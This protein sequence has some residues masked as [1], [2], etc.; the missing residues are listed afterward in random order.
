MN[1]G[2]ISVPRPA[3]L[4]D[5]EKERIWHP[6]GLQNRSQLVDKGLTDPAEMICRQFVVLWDMV[7]SVGHILY[8]WLTVCNRLKNASHTHRYGCSEISRHELQRIRFQVTEDLF[9]WKASLPSALEV[10]LNDDTIP[11]LPHLL[12]LQQVISINRCFPSCLRNI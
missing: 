6:Y 10:D 9:A 4:I 8:V 5:A 2:D 7:S 1:A 11:K 12:L 3:A